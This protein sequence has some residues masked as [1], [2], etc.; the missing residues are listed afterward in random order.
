[1]KIDI[2]K[3]LMTPKHINVQGVGG[4]TSELLKHRYD[5]LHSITSSTSWEA[6]ISKKFHAK[7]MKTSTHN[8]NIQKSKRKLCENYRAISMVSSM[9]AEK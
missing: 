8:V 4:I 7:S 2:Q 9:G 6:M 3:R 5:K 1:M